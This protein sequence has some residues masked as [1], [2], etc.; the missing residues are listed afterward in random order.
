MHENDFFIIFLLD[1][2][3]LLLIHRSAVATFLQR[4]LLPHHPEP[5]KIKET[6]LTLSIIS[7]ISI[8]DEK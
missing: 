8:R 2:T 1:L 5:E 3:S 7:V 4:I 6:K